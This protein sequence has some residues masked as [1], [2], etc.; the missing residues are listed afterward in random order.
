MTYMMKRLKDECIIT[1]EPS[2]RQVRGFLPLVP[3]RDDRVIDM[4]P[5]VPYDGEQAA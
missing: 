1:P 3:F 4:V 2:I 5:P